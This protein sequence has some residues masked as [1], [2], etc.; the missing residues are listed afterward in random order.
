[1]PRNSSGTYSTPAGQPVV[2][3]TVISAATENTLVSDISTEITDS[4]SRSGKGGMSAPIRTPDGAVSAPAHSFTNE[5]GTGLY[6][7]GASDVGLAI[8]GVKTHEFTSSSETV[9]H[10]MTVNNN[11]IVNNTLTAQYFGVTGDSTLT[12]NLAVNGTTGATVS[13]N[14]TV[15]GTTG[16]AGISLPAA[17][18]Q[19]IT[20]S[21]GTLNVGTTDANALALQSSNTTRFTL[22]STGNLQ[23]DGTHTVTNL[24]TPSNSGDAANKGYVDGGGAYVA[25]AWAM[26]TLGGAGAVTVTAGHGV[27]SASWSGNSLTVGL[28]PA[29]GSA[30]YATFAT[31]ATVQV[32]LAVGITNS[33]QFIVYQTNSGGSVNWANGQVVSVLVFAG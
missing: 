17:A 19:W 14:L 23:S 32:M 30:N 33:S 1:M 15:N 5:T 26:L 6:R 24:P 13:A 28:S 12:G 31:V 9:N 27:G 10:D 7:I 2:S 20:K 29:M 4:L 18:S 25:K 16:A 21:G 11:L 22:L 3:G 8:A